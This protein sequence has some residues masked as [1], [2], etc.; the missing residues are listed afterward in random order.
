MPFLE[1]ESYRSKYPQLS[2]LIAHLQVYLE[3]ELERTIE[4]L[5]NPRLPLHDVRPAHLS[6][7][8]SVDE[9]LALTLLMMAEDAGLVEHSYKIYCPGT[10][11]FLGE[12]PLLESIPTTVRCPYHEF[13]EIDHDENEYLLDAVFHF[14]ERVLGIRTHA[15]A[16]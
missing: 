12:Y 6:T 13:G 3:R 9:G 7:K 1:L 10:N 15:I 8:L 11:N 4:Q 2:E 14:T 5:R 16:V